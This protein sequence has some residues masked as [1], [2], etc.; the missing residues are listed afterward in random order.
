MNMIEPELLADIPRTLPIFKDGK[1]KY[2]DDYKPQHYHHH[3]HDAQKVNG[4]KPIS[5]RQ[6]VSRQ[7]RGH[8]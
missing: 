5:L 8:K 3:H 7:L 4:T 1:T 6:P 2:L